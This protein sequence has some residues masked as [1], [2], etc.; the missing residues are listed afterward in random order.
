MV[1]KWILSVFIILAGASFGQYE[2][3]AHSGSMYL[4]TTPEGAN[5][6]A[7]ASET[8]FPL[9]VRLDRDWFD[10]SQ[11]AVN[12]DDIRFSTIG[13][14]ALAYQIEQW[15]PSN[16][17]A[18]IWVRIPIIKGNDRQEIKM[19]WGKA[20][21]A[22][23][24]SGPDVFN[25]SNGYLCVWHMSE[26][27]KD[28]VGHLALTDTG[29]LPTTGM[30]GQG[31]HFPGGKG[32]TAGENITTFP[33]GS[34]P[35][36]SEAWVRAERGNGMILAWGNEQAQGKV[37][38]KFASPPHIAMDC[39][40]SN[41]NVEGKS[42]LEQSQ[43]VHVVHAYTNGVSKVY[44]NGVLDGERMSSGSPLNIGTPARMF[45]G[46]WYHN[47]SF[48]GDIDELRI[49]KVTRSA[50]WVKLE[51]ENQRAQQSALGPLVQKGSE[52]SLSQVSIEI[53][54]GERALITAKAGGAQKIYWVVKSGEQETI[55]A[56]D[57][58][59]FSFDAGR[60]KGDKTLS[61]KC[62]AVFAD[63]VKTIE[64]PVTIKE[65]IPEPVFTLD[66]P[67]RWNG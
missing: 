24:C 10:F 47:Y 45:V 37:T 53:A 58:F 64:I 43:W 20:G 57:Q 16:G 8:G 34:D 41:G 44:V 6:P 7:S 63:T 12:G 2:D 28:D 3:W 26:P 23:E 17:V 46:G 66:S 27:V 11:A 29:T 5:L 56:V 18:S 31:R 40:F 4:L 32:I 51:Y 19:F 60:V 49:S 1:T 15:E 62:K 38:M 48:M 14:D 30:V 67:V 33:V 50:D 42:R 59:K 61:I 54:E 13:G 35:H 52:F 65:A 55:A 9:L 21:A 39:Y 25:E 36:S 22:G